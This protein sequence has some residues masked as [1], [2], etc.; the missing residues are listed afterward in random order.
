MPRENKEPGWGESTVASHP[1][2][3]IVAASVGTHGLSAG[4]HRRV[5][6]THPCLGRSCVAEIAHQSKEFGT[7]CFSPW[8]WIFTALFPVRP[9]PLH[10]P[11]PRVR[12][13]TLGFTFESLTHQFDGLTGV[14][15][16]GRISLMRSTGAM[17]EMRVGSCDVLGT[18]QIRSR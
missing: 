1:H 14:L 7:V 12:V 5:L 10:L 4:D 15:R 3:A 16:C 2:L 6:D 9:F 11:F 18:A 13:D 8:T 17:R